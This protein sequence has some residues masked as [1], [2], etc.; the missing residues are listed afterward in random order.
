MNTFTLEDTI[1]TFAH[2]PSDVFPCLLLTT[3]LHQL[4]MHAQRREPIKTALSEPHFS[5]DANFFS[6]A[7]IFFFTQLGF[8]VQTIYNSFVKQKATS[9]KLINY[10]RGR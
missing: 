2:A 3:N 10:T 6:R 1:F 5:L 4:I 8:D 9:E 7:R